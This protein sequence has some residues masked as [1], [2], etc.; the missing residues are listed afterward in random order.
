[1]SVKKVAMT[2]D[3]FW[4]IVGSVHV[5]GGGDMKRKCE[6]IG[7][8]LRKLTAEEV[9]SFN[10]YYDDLYYSAYSWELWDAAELI[11][12][13]CGDDS[14]MDFRHTL[15][16]MGREIY[17]KAMS[18]PD[19]LAELDLDRESARFE[20]YQYA[21]SHACEDVLRREGKEESGR[22]QKRPKALAGTRT[23]EWELEKR[24]PNL[25]AKCGHKDADHLF[26]K[27]G[28]ERWKEVKRQFGRKA[29]SE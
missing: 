11:C 19:S 2:I 28:V 14:F 12:G 24:F 16:S 20:G 26:K 3:Q 29:G 21:V 22:R 6:L 7:A 27:E 25:A 23:E 4:S 13:G 18:N 15:I 5:A 9:Q 10:N 1:M 17:E 8:E